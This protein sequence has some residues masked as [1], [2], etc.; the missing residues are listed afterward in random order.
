MANADLQIE[1]LP[2][3]RTA[4]PEP[5]NDMPLPSDPGTIFLG[6]LF[7]LA[8]LAAAYVASE[9]ILPLMFAITLKL[10]LQPVM[11]L[12]EKLKIPRI[13]AALVLIVV[14][15]F[16]IY[17]LAAL[18]TGPAEAWI[19][20]LPQA[21]PVLQQKLSLIRHPLDLLQHAMKQID[22]LGASGG[23][24]APASPILSASALLGGIFTSAR[25]F[26]SALFTTILFLYFLLLS[27]DTFLRRFVE[28]LPRFSAKRQAVDISL[29]VEDD[30]S[31]Y[32]A[33]I[34]VMNALVG[35][36]T[37]L[38]MHLTGV[39]DPLLWGVL[40][41]LLNFAPIIGP[42]I[43]IFLFLFAGLLTIDNEWRAL[44]P[45]AGYFIVHLIE[46]ETLTPM[47]LA[48]RFTVNPLLVVVSLVFWSWMWGIPG[49]ILSAPMLAILKIV[50]DRVRQFAALGHILEG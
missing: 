42:I 12:L 31:A 2:I 50:C 48:R 10:M 47:L 17:M 40:A 3:E 5:A 7:F 30:I 4:T 22:A 13:I 16:S 41:F 11:R 36:A 38:I 45:A 14:L 26:F 19:S 33:T 46:G 25:G 43:A 18:I 44:A 29:Q 9:I 24:Q 23:A 1:T 35:L 39:G 15:F 8:L 37:A 6:G 28:I 20:R 34:T 32:L 27:G 49:A 21:A